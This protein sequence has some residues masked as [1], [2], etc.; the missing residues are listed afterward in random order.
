MAINFPVS[1]DDLAN[2]SAGDTIAP[3]HKNDLNDIVEALEAKVGIDSSAVATSHDYL[4]T[5][6]PAQGQNLDIGAYDLRAQT[7]TSDIVTG[8]KPLNIT[9]TT[10]CDNLN[11]DQL[12]GVEGAGYQ[13]ILTN[14][15]GLAAAISDEEGTG[16][17]VFNTSPTLVTPVLGVATATSI[18]GLTIDTT[19]GTLDVTN[20][21]TLTVTG[22]ATISATPYTPGGTDVAIADGG[23]GAG[24]AQN[25][26][27][28]L[29]P[30]QTGNANKFLQTD[31]TNVSWQAVDLSTDIT[32]VLP[33]ANNTAGAV[34]QTVNTITGAVATGTVAAIPLDDTIPQITEGEQYM[35]LAITPLSATNKLKIEVVWIGAS[36]ATSPFLTVA[37]FQDSTANALACANQV[38][39]QNGIETIKFT[40]YMVAG[41]TSSTTF[42]VRAGSTGV[43]TITFNGRTGGR[44]YGGVLASSITI[45]EI[46]A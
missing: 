15:A 11:A 31:A 19:T 14:S 9:S 4:L 7:L 25:A 38:S 5:H 36:N 16:K 12:D 45:H 40:H 39:D 37:L 27:N 21:K 42:R 1:L 6:L 8:T 41:T 28:A 2:V 32:G 23:T 10:M 33:A 34:V 26:R 22:D 3:A 46:A 20:A 13:T 30:T 17:V 29:L 44:L 18:N 24:T 35:T 43:S